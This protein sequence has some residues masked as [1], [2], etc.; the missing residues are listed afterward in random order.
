M[1]QGVIYYKTTEDK[2]PVAPRC[3]IKIIISEV[4]DD[5]ATHPGWKVAKTMIENKWAWIDWKNEVKEVVGSCHKCQ[6]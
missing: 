3:L 2:V 5:L 1:E 4:H 6:L